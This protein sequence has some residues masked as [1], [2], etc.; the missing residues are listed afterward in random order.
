MKKMFLLFLLFVV[1]FSA[2]G[3][4][5][6]TEDAAD[7]PDTVETVAESTAV[8]SEPTPEPAFPADIADS[9]ALVGLW[10][11]S[12][13]GEHGYMVFA[14]DG[15]Y[16]LS[17]I[18]DTILNEPRVTG[19]YWLEDGQFHL[20]DE[21][22]AGHWTDCAEEGI[23]GTTVAEDGTLAFVTI[24]DSCNEGGFARNYV[25]QNT[26]WTRIGDVPEGSDAATA[27]EPGVDAEAL[28]Q[29]L[30]G[31]VENYVGAQNSGVVLL[32]DAPDLGFSW[33]G[34]AGMADPETGV[35]MMADDQFIISSS[36]KMYTAVVILKL[37]EEGKLNLDDPISNYLPEDLVSQIHRLD[38]HSYGEEITVRQLL[39]HTSGLGDFSNG[40]DADEDGISD[41]KELIL[42]EPETLWDTDMV[43][44]WAIEN[45]APVGKPGEKFFYSDT[46]FQLLA[47]IIEIVSGMTL[48]DAY[49]Q[50][51]FE[52]L[53]MVHTYFEFG[54]DVV[55]GVD[56]RPLSQA[57]YNGTNW[58]ELTSH[59]YEF[60]SGGLVS[61]V[62]DQNRFLW[63]WV[64]DELFSDPNLKAEMT[65]WVA[66]EGCGAYYGLGTFNI[67]FE[68][69]DIPA[70]GT[71]QGHSGLMNNLAFYWPE[72]NVTIIGT[73]NTNEPQLG[74]I[75]MMLDT[76]FALLEASVE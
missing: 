23:Y 74:F 73:L 17:L 35:E 31:I 33:K 10:D 24:E 68:E 28:A 27:V 8:P 3:D 53:G 76:M 72:Q 6:S 67:V 70:V 56:G 75:G 65:E 37:I 21:E 50:M 14:D 61:T 58:N 66:A 49:R 30:Q 41:F 47:Q 71:V 54:E 18:R 64:N 43:L 2:C 44:E 63:A 4:N 57:F 16:Y 1:I 26:K 52:P 48:A 38:G 34:A 20:R 12:L 69:C 7:E 40:V 5:S 25:M 29:T 9:A 22:N 19:E 42:A 55:A 45:A 59:S 60:G 11:G 36:T 62:D 15:T 46:N 51:I 32:V 39:N 13:G